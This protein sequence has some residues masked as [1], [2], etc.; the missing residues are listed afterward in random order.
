MK[1]IHALKAWTHTIGSEKSQK[2]SS[3]FDYLAVIKYCTTI[4][5]QLTLNTSLHWIWE[6]ISC[7]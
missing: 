7:C 5:K 3:K 6:K 2:L 4:I 1:L